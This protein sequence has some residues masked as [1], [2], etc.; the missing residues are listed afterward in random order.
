MVSFTCSLN[1]IRPSSPARPWNI[2]QEAEKF[3]QKQTAAKKAK[4]AAKEAAK[5]ERF[6]VR[7][8][9]LQRLLA[10]LGRDKKPQRPWDI[11]GEA[12]QFRK[13]QQNRLRLQDQVR[14][15]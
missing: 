14:N 12:E 7:E 6:R 15:I 2:R 11:R 5:E 10:K 8:N 13:N 1:N 4:E 9:E 3:R